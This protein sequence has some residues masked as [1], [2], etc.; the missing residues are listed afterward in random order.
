L[1]RDPFGF[2]SARTLPRQN[3]DFSEIPFHF[4]SLSL[5]MTHRRDG[6]AQTSGAQKRVTFPFGE[7]SARGARDEVL[8]KIANPR[9][10]HVRAQTNTAIAT[11]LVCTFCLL[12]IILEKRY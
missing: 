11:N 8:Q 2:G 9:N 12:S 3:F 4:I 7:D 10:L 1:F 5:R 6:C